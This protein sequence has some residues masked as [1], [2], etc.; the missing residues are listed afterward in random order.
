MTTINSNLQTE[1]LRKTVL[2]SLENTSSAQFAYLKYRNMQGELSTYK[3]NLNTDFMKMYK[4]D[5]N[6]LKNMPINELSDEL[7]I[8]AR[9][10]LIESVEKAIVTEFQHEKNPNKNM[11]SLHKS[12]MFHDEKNE[13]YLK[14]VCLEKKVIE[15]GTYKVVN[16]RD[17]TLVKNRIKNQLKQSKIRNFRINLNQIKK[18]TTNNTRIVIVAD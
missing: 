16:S 12:L 3:L 4:D 7:E 9:N 13:M 11:T 5:L 18:I 8:Q 17:L 14:A 2:S 6:T 10:E 15:P 1:E